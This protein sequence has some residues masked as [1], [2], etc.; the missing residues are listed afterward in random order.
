[1]VCSGN[2]KPHKSLMILSHKT[3]YTNVLEKLDSQSHSSSGEQHGSFNMSA[4]DRRYLE[5]QLVQLAKGIWDHLVQ[6]G[7]NLTAEYLPRK[8]NV[9]AD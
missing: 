5:F 7:I 8:L 2:K 6:C 4:K 3:I 9:T 1:M